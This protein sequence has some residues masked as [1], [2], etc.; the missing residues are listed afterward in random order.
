MKKNL[1]ILLL[2]YCTFFNGWAQE[3]KTNMYLVN[4]Q[5]VF[6]EANGMVAVE[7]EFF[8]QQTNTEKRQWYVTHKKS[9][10]AVQPDA[11]EAHIAGAS[12]N[13]YIEILP[14]TRATHSDQ[15]IAAENFSNEP[16]MM[17][18][19]H[20]KVNIN[21]PGRYYVWV[22][23]HST[24]S[25]DNGL[26]VGIDGTWPEHGQRMQWCDGKNDW[27]WE[28][29]Q[30]TDAEHC[31]VAKEIYLDIDRAGIH[32][33]QF[34]MREDGFE[35]DKFLLTDDENY[36]PE[37]EG[38]QL[39][40]KS[41][42]V[43]ARFPKVALTYFDQLSKIVPGV[44]AMKA[45]RFPVEATNFYLDNNWLAVNPERS[46][47]ARTTSLFT[48]TDGVYDLVF[49]GV[50]ENDGQSS[51]EVLVN[52]KEV[53]RLIVPLSKSSFEEGVQYNDLWENINLKNGDKITV[54]AK[55]GSKDGQEFSR[56]RW[57]GLVFAPMTKGKDVLELAK[58]LSTRQDVGQNAVTTG[59]VAESAPKEEKPEVVSKNGNGEVVISG[60]LKQWH[61]VTLTLDGPFAAETDQRPNPFTDYRMTVTFTHESGSP[62][63][64]V[65]AYF[66]ADGNASETS[67]S[68]GIKWRAHLSPDKTGTWNYSISFLQGAM[69]AVADM[70]WM[71]TLAAYDGISGSFEVGETD[72][73]GC[74][75]RAKG[76][77][78]Y[79]GKHHL[80]FKG[81][82][83]FFYKAGSDAP[84]TLL[85]YEDFD[86]TV[87]MKAKVPLKKLVAHRQDYKE[88]DPSWKGGKGKA[89]IG[90]VN[91]L[92]DKG[93]NAFSFLTYNAGGDGD[94]VWPFVGR[95]DKM[96][97]DCSK[98][99]QWGIVFDFAQ[100]KGMYLHFKTQETEN[101]DNVRG[102]DKEGLVPEALD[103]GDLGPERRLYYRELVARYGYLLALN[104]NL[105]EENTQ[106]GENHI[107]MADWFAE[108]DPY[109]HNLV[110]H[111][112]PNE[113]DKRYEPLLGNKSE[114]T[115]VSL[116]NMWDAV[117]KQTLKWVVESDVA[118]KPWVV[119]NDE[120]GSAG[121][122][123]PAD[124]GYKGFDATT[125]GYTIHDVRKQT[126]WGNIMAGGAGVEYYF[127]YQL[128][129]NDLVMEDFRSR[130]KSW[131]YCR[132]AINFLSDNGIPFQDM[133]NAD[134][135]IGN[136][137]MD[138]DKHCLAKPGEIYLVQLA[139]V[140]SST[141][142]LSGVAGDF[143]VEWFN[144]ATGG[145]LQV[146]NVKKVKGGGV[147]EL[148][149][150][151]V[152]G[153]D[154]WLVLVRKK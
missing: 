17:A 36:R 38:P 80:Q 105:G 59:G 91:Y 89:L 118:G 37:G 55:V 61:K 66:A 1:T 65:P 103:G 22:R 123:V 92:A 154:D 45:T 83:E 26:H 99:D 30:R 32:D 135:L 73:T 141:L 72:K 145:K 2:L 108:N 40:I 69:V 84:E 4:D 143:T 96:H 8:Y 62:S 146:G 152:A 119:A 39:K 150:A 97:Y 149:K 128:P 116:Q 44:V 137:N 71:K 125:V 5:L 15:L 132:I 95:D 113:Q 130:D 144:P 16:G 23:S 52:E 142:D 33:I 64:R 18:V 46:K 148:G 110:L 129:E 13:A 111:T 153:G 28:S 134:K 112:F 51:Y 56:G 70:P 31:G 93:L 60:E 101:D 57:A 68:E 86:N 9:I 100:T 114:L 47:E 117:F 35:L 67:A 90:A 29:K 136:T 24:G 34:S 131:D 107:A 50:G 147:V 124:P 19:V 42:E 120:Q 58:S 14:D 25:E 78:E 10:P 53:G 41:G 48:G 77:L 49:V 140:I 109:R 106:S 121:K 74:D 85:G 115:G 21:K 133:K 76:R 104:W 98:L 79:V 3:A 127:G 6:D 151:P 87:A 27:T 138:K 139:Y 54:I 75:L 94:N 82:G 81:T 63:Y 11:D 126:L 12:N 122:G 20:Y 88:G 102:H 7:A 43:P